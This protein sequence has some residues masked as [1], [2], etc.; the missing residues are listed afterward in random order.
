MAGIVLATVGTQLCVVVPGLTPHLR[1]TTGLTRS[2]LVTEVMTP[3]LKG[4][5]PVGLV[6][7][8]FGL[9]TAPP[10]W[11][12]LPLGCL[13]GAAYLWQTRAVYL[14]YPPLSRI[15]QRA[16]GSLVRVLHR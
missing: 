3:W 8:A 7:L 9:F 10:V 4:F 1:A 15:W 11:M 16:T 2:A 12:G 13:L 14:R 6:A 5:V